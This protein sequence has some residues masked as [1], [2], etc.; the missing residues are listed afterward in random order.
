MPLTNS[1]GNSPA[2][3]LFA[4]ANASPEKEPSSPASPATSPAAPPPSEKPQQTSPALARKWEEY[5]SR[6]TNN[7]EH[8][9]QLVSELS[10]AKQFNEVIALLEQALIAGQA[11]PWMYEVLAL[12]MELAGRPRP[13]IER[14]LLSSQ[15]LTPPD[16][17]S[18]LFLA[19]YLARFERYAP[20]IKCCRQ[21]AALEPQ[22]PEPY[23][24]ALRLA[25]RARDTET[26]AWASVGVLHSAWGQK[27]VAYREDAEAAVIDVRKEWKQQS[28]WMDLTSY[29]MA[30][31]EAR[32]VDLRI[33]VEWAGAGDLDLEVTEPHGT[34]CNRQNPYSTGGGI[35]AHD[36]SGPVAKNCYDEYVCPIAWSGEYQLKIDRTWGNIVGRRATVVITRHADE[37]TGMKEVIPVTI[38]TEPNIIRIN[39]KDGRRQAATAIPQ[40]TSQRLRTPTVLQQLSNGNSAAP[41][42][43]NG[44][45][46]PIVQF[47]NEG[48]SMSA[49]AVVSGD[50]RY[51]R[52]S[53]NPVF[54]DVTDVFTFSFQR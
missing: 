27:Q 48:I 6:K 31:K 14:V 15:D 41:A 37:E 45:Y 54:S 38:S 42:T 49:L 23:I 5:F 26:L 18:L 51:V 10:T 22:R 25:R 34:L 43:G 52:L 8:V 3:F 16:T 29:E 30:L 50:R 40:R 2:A 53:L 36:G 19:A 46:Q 39:L 1:F 12:T 47:M 4:Q 35:L 7:P 32:R 28:R 33:R 11:Q 17:N 20:A 24:E 21:A 9:R 44:G 13:Q